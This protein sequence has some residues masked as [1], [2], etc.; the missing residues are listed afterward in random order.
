MSGG[1]VNSSIATTATSA[2]DELIKLESAPKTPS[3]SVEMN[4][5]PSSAPE[6]SMNAPQSAGTTLEWPK[7][8]PHAFKFG[9][10]QEDCG[11]FSSNF[12]GGAM[13]ASIMRVDMKEFWP[14]MGADD[15]GFMEMAGQYSSIT[16]AGMSTACHAFGGNF[17]ASTSSCSI[18]ACQIQPA[19]VADPMF[20]E[21]NFTCKNDIQVPA[22]LD[23]DKMKITPC[24]PKGKADPLNV[25]SY[26]LERANT[27]VSKAFNPAAVKK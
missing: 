18:K 23:N 16:N 5:P 25:I 14:M 13:R 26:L 20:N 27:F 10:S 4:A 15:K 24:V 12:G 19:P 7:Y 6:P 8:F 22:T 1:N 2:P 11:T 17:D 9:E 3:Y 21:N